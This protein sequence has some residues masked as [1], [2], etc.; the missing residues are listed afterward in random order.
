[1]TADVT[2]VDLPTTDLL[3]HAYHPFESDILTAV[4]AR[5]E[6]SLAVV[7]RRVAFA[8]LMY[9]QAVPAVVVTFDRFDW[10]NVIRY[11]QSVRGHYNW[12]FVAN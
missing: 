9:T 5:L 8:Y 12:L 1:M 3:I 6:T 7:P 10:L 4:L 2:T 11:E